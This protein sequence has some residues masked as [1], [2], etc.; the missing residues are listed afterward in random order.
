MEYFAGLLLFIT[1]SVVIVFTV[2]RIVRRGNRGWAL[3]LVGS[4]I[5]TGIFTCASLYYFTGVSCNKGNRATFDQCIYFS[6]VT[7]TTLGF[8]DYH[9]DVGMSQTIAAVESIIGY[10]YMGVAVAFILN[11]FIFTEETGED[12]ERLRK[13]EY[14]IAT[15]LMLSS[16]QGRKDTPCN[17]DPKKR[18]NEGR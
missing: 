11:F 18:S 16:M 4:A 1:T 7:W 14:Q 2:P 17:A 6:V 5:V 12:K 15:L 13:L 9:P 3:I 8:G 10:V